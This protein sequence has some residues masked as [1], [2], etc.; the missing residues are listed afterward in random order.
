MM[1]FEDIRRARSRIREAR[2]PRSTT[3]MSAPRALPE[4]AH[5]VGS[6]PPPSFWLIPRMG[7]CRDRVRLTAVEQLGKSNGASRM[8]IR[9]LKLP[10]EGAS[11]YPVIQ[12]A[13][14]CPLRS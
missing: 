14:G 6:A 3:S 4:A 2:F 12:W 8:Y 11:G 9:M 13:P 5:G 7:R 10:I 1:T